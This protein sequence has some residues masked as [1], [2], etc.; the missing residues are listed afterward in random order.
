MISV[1][2]AHSAELQTRGLQ[3][4]QVDAEHFDPGVGPFDAVVCSSV[5]EYIEDDLGLLKR[6]IASLRPGG[7]LFV[8]VPHKANLF[9]PLEP[10]AHYIKLRLKGQTEG[11]L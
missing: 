3:F 7:Y 11:H 6:L 4:E 5:M 8:S 10:L 1:G 9:A 2:R